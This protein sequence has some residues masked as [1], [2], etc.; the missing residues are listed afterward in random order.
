MG[1]GKDAARGAVS[2]PVA[3]ILILPYTT[4]D[5]IYLFR[6]NLIVSA[7]YLQRTLHSEAHL[8]K[9]CSSDTLA[10]QILA[11]VTLFCVFRLFYGYIYAKQS[12]SKHNLRKDRP[13]EAL[14]YQIHAKACSILPMSIELVSHLLETLR[15]VLQPSH[16]LR[17]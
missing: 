11:K 16:G 14:A 1:G 9:D 7:P 13:S 15:F 4:M 5:N 17:A 8:R 12:I 3:P 2:Q 6:A 10:Y